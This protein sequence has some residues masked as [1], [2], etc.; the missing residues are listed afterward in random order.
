MSLN[1]VK[2]GSASGG[3]P[4]SRLWIDVCS[5]MM[6]MLV[7]TRS[8]GTEASLGNDM[9]IGHKVVISLH[10]QFFAQLTS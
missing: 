7:H 8:L 4:H 3:L 6:W 1:V 2:F 10:M 9:A 5:G